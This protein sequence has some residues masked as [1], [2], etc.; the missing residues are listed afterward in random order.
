MIDI[1]EENAGIAGATSRLSDEESG[2][3]SSQKVD[4]INRQ[5]YNRQVPAGLQMFK[6]SL[7]VREA[8]A[9]CRFFPACGN[10]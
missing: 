1:E 9:S 7:L 2:H 5:G 3:F 6:F 10:G 8:L 4:K